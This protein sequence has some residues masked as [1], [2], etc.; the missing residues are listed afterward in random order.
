MSSVI[1]KT[2]HISC[3]YPSNSEPV[4]SPVIV[5]SV[6]S[7]SPSSMLSVHGFMVDTLLIIFG[8][9]FPSTFSF[10]RKDKKV[11][12]LLKIALQVICGIL[13]SSMLLSLERANA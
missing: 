2:H 5:G 13:T 12:Q 1:Y 8:V 3:F 7:N 6:K 4:L 11:R 10:K 9:I